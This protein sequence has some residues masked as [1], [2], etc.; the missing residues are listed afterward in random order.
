MIF[1]ILGK[2]FASAAIMQIFPTKYWLETAIYILFKTFPPKLVSIRRNIYPCIA[3]HSFNQPHNPGICNCT[4]KSEV[5]L[6]NK[7]PTTPI[8][9][10]KQAQ[11]TAVNPRG[12]LLA[13]TLVAGEFS[14]ALTASSHPRKTK[15]DSISWQNRA[16]QVRHSA[17]M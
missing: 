9:P 10:P 2:I 1:R 5:D 15:K 12:V 16:F 4:C 13:S 8:W 6:L 3:I 7:S 14:K 17:E 11:W